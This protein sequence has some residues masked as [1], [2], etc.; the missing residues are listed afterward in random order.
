M[1]HRAADFQK[2]RL[3]KPGRVA[4]IGVAAA[5][6]L[7]IAA[8]TFEA[9]SQSQAIGYKAPAGIL[10]ATLHIQVDG[11]D[12]AVIPNGRFVTPVGL[13]LGVGAPKPF[14]MAVTQDGGTL[15]TVNSGIGPFSVTLVKKLNTASPQTTVIPLNA[16]FLGVILSPDGSRFYVSGG[17]NGNIWVGETASGTIVGSVN[18]NTT[19]HPTGGMN[20]TNGPVSYFKGTYPGRLVLSSDGRYLYT[21]DQGGFQVLVID[22]TKIVTGVDSQGNLMEPDNFA[23]AVGAVKVG[24][25]PFGLALS[26]DN[27]TLYVTNVGVF[28]YSSLR[29]S[30]PVG[31]NNVDFPLCYPGA[32]YPDE[33][34][35]D[36]QITIHKVD[37]RNL[38]TA[39]SFPDGIAC[40]YIAQDQSFT[41]P[42]LGSPNAPEASSV[43]VFDASNPVEPSLVKVVKAGPRVGDVQEGVKTYGG[44]HPNAVAIGGSYVYVANGSD[45]TISVLNRKSSQEIRRISLSLFEGADHRIKGIQPVALA[46]SPDQRTLYVAEAG[47]NAI[48]VVDLSAEPEDA[49]VRGLIPTGWWPSSVSVGADGSTLY[50]ASANGRGAE[51]NDSIPPNNLGSPKSSTLGT[52]HV[53]AVPSGKQL[54]DYTHRVLANNGFIPSRVPHEPNP[55]PSEPGVPSPQIRHVIF[56]N[57][58]NATHD[59]L[60]GDITRTRT[61]QPVAGDPAYSLGYAA[62]PNH[63]ELALRFTFSDNFFLEPSVSSDGHRWLNDNFT[64]E[65]EQTHWAASYGGERNDSGD[66]PNVFVPY[67][68]RLGFTD[69]NS[70]PEPNDYDEHGGIFAHLARN[71]KD[72]VNFGNGFEFAIVDEDNATEPTGI[73]NHVNVPMEKILRDHSDHFYPEFNTHIPDGLLPED[74]T[75]FTR[76][77]RFQQVFESHYVN[78]E[79]GVCNLPS[80]VDLYFPNDHG[81]GA[82]DINPNGPAWSFV[83]FVQDNDAALGETVDLISHSPCWK[84]TVIFVVEDDPQNGFDHVN[85]TRSLFLAISPWVKHQYLSKNH[86]SLASIFKTLNLILG[87][88]PLNQYDAGATDLRDMFTSAPDFT[89]YNFTPIAF[90]GTPNATWTAMTKT[91]NFSKPDLNEVELRRAIQLSEGIPHRK[92]GKK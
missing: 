31:T 52:V 69:A 45:D 39:L 65:F 5:G 10:P 42:G 20:V 3:S 48:A 77:G 87:I 50:V 22:T 18:L 56:I 25:Y 21:T 78:R 79:N 82:F 62:S 81:G 12:A 75:R 17:E 24:R 63:H 37:P 19:S 61:G 16:A 26:S 46:L 1:K 73:R 47:I 4:L 11:Y 43:Y 88:P 67:P 91:L 84:D 28:Q 6:L 14:G 70:S 66:D 92:P 7:S 83:R 35:S 2:P 33:T 34:A 53:L 55:I 38:P 9:A 72:F 29:P 8:V 54:S 51:P 58:E 57:K 90:A 15:A 68:G 86:Y 64:T 41:V 80:Y 23:A 49:Q 71:G 36:R 27:R 30:D 74:P 32:G 85:G 40:G 44:S 60:L 76:F 13:E 89:P 59:L